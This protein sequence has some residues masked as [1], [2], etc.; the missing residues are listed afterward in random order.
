MDEGPNPSCTPPSQ[1]SQ[2][3]FL[4]VFLTTYHKGTFGFF[5]L[6]VRMLKL[7]YL[8]TSRPY[9]LESATLSNRLYR[10]P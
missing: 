5:P 7:A 10:K 8:T 2:L 9:R 6:A 4:K 1:C 3:P